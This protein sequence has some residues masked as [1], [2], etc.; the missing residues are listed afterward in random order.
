MPQRAAP[1]RKRSKSTSAAA[2]IIGFVLV[3]LGLGVLGLG[4]W[5][6]KLGLETEGWPKVRATIAD[7]WMTVSRNRDRVDSVLGHH[8]D[9]EFLNIRYAY[10]VDGRDY[11][12]TSLE[13]GG[14]FQNAAWAREWRRNRHTGDL[15]TVA[16]NP[17]DPT[18]A[19]LFPGISTT[20]KLAGGLGLAFLVVGGWTLVA[21]ARRRA[22]QAR[23]S[24]NKFASGRPLL[25][26]R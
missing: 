15:T 13:R 26:P 9:D 22:R 23:M 5:S 17:D 11:V 21:E 19:Y 8:K 25:H 12:G 3:G 10:V 1:T 6:A 16:V 24:R 18:E 4:A 2:L 7:A 20:A 14:G